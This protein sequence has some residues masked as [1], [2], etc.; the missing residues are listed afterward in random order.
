MNKEEKKEQLQQKY[1]ELQLLEK[2][3]SEVQNHLEL[4]HNQSQELAKLKENLDDLKKTRKGKQVY[5]QIGSGIFIKTELKDNEKILMN[6]G[7]NSVVQKT[8]PE[9]QELIENQK[10]EVNNS[11]KEIE[12]KLG[13]AAVQIQKTREELIAISKD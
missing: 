2:H 1:A 13:E 10:K 7:A 6:V 8:I 9:A 11:I 4:L 5:S 3:I 12:S